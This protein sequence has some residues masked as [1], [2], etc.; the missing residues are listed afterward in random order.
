MTIASF[1]KAVAPALLALGAVIVGWVTTG[2]F[3]TGEAL[4]AAGGLLGS[5]AVY[6]VPN[7]AST[8][9]LKAL[10]PAFMGLVAVAQRAIETGSFEEGEWRI[11]IGALVMAGLVYVVPNATP[12]VIGVGNS[13]AGGTFTH[14]PG[15][16]LT[17]STTRP[18]FTISG[19]Q[20]H[21]H[22]HAAMTEG[23]VFGEL[24]KRL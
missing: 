8:P 14:A 21:N 12:A 11:A 18:V 13:A 22:V 3:S 15:Q 19:P 1:R 20:H 10:V 7:V 2:D 16:T 23:S 5:T 6:V 4:M 17:F 24:R 9:F